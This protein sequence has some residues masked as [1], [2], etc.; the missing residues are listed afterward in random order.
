MTKQERVELGFY[1]FIDSD[2]FSLFMF[3]KNMEKPLQKT[4][5]ILVFSD[6]SLCA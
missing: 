3:F 2:N 5:S 4:V 1:M 6:S